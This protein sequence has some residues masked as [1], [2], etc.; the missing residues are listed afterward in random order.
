MD[1]PMA[2]GIREDPPGVQKEKQGHALRDVRIR[3]LKCLLVGS[4]GV[5]LGLDA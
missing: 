5:D 2:G 1:A 4:F 3:H